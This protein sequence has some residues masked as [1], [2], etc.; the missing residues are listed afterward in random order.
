MEETEENLVMMTEIFKGFKDLSGLEINEGETKAI[1]IGANHNDQTP[2][3]DKVK[4][5]YVKTFKLLS[6][7][8]DNKLLNLE[9]NFIERK[10][11][12]R[13]KIA[14]WRK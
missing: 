7:N 5:K 9:E 3:K 10:K 6:I 4:Y 2:K 13:P 12:I 14:I 1:R 8:I 11:N